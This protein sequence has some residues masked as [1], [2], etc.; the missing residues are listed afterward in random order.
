[1][2]ISLIF[3]YLWSSGDT[4][5]R[6]RLL[7]LL[8]QHRATLA[9]V[10]AHLD[11][12]YTDISLSTKEVSI[13]QVEIVWIVLLEGCCYQ[14][15]RVMGWEVLAFSMHTKILNGHT[16]SHTLYLQ[17]AQARIRIA[18]MIV[19]MGGQ[20]EIEK[21]ARRPM[22]PLPPEEPPPLPT[23]LPPVLGAGEDEVNG[24]ASVLE[25]SVGKERDED[26]SP[27]EE[28]ESRRKDGT[29][30]EED[31]K[32]KK[33]LRSPSWEVKEGADGRRAR[34][35][36][37]ERGLRSEN[38]DREDRGRD[39][40]R[41]RRR[42]KTDEGDGLGRHVRREQLSDVEIDERTLA[43][44]R[45][46]RYARS[47]VERER[48]GG[49]SSGKDRDRERDRERHREPGRD[50]NRER[51]RDRDRERERDR[52][53]ARERDRERDRDRLRNEARRR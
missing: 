15:L 42:A 37:Y 53:R 13:V 41:E 21:L 34:S 24:E 23:D 29:I 19:A 49:R 45:D 4:L 5:L 30:K 31:R 39:Y 26:Y 17:G 8:H 20:I 44:D 18:K 11:S 46:R 47:R 16:R 40:D 51:D 2:Q 7:L 33:G 28:D 9:T 27:T 25:A 12:T 3:G 43:R 22:P 35:R 52:A 10:R 36:E 32:E 38:G 1:V 50:R 48:E 6:K 14:R